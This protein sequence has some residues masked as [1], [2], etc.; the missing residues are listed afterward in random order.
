[1]NCPYCNE[2]LDKDMCGQVG[3][4]NDHCKES[5]FL[6][7]TEELW[8][9][10][11]KTKQALDV[12]VDA[13]N[14]CHETFTESEAYIVANKHNRIANKALDQIKKITETKDVNNE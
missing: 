7:G 13:L 2:E 12:A 1:M 8:Q 6:I 5:M 9:E 3:C 14:K 4:R 10:L 11:I